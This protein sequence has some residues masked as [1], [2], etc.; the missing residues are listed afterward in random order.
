MGL[1]P[2]DFLGDALGLG[3]SGGFNPFG[4]GSGGGS[5]GG[6]VGGA[7][8][9]LFGSFTPAAVP[10][11]SLYGEAAN[12]MGTYKAVTPSIYDLTSQWTPQFANLQR[13]IVTGNTQAM[14]TGP[15]AVDPNQAALLAEMNKQA[16]SELQ[17]G[18]TLDPSL[19]REVEQSVRG[20]Q[21]ARGMVTGP[22][23]VYDE[24]MQI[25][26]AGQALRNQRRAYAGNVAGMNLSNITPYLGLAD[27]FSKAG[28]SFDPWNSYASDL[29]NT[30]YNAANARNIAAAA[31][32][33]AVAGATLGAAGKVAGALI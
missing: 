28:P 13:G 3:G 18:A 16:L 24:A 22:A 5:G 19:R 32:N 31:N 9:G 33:A 4:G 21:A 15:T 11:R 27:Q 30:N 8:Q 29:Y 12:T 20:G 25:G 1:F 2:G 23:Q 6:L 17:Q 14:T 26:S 10:D 7:L